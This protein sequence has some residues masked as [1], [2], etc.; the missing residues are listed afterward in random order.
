MILRGFGDDELQD[1][2]WILNVGSRL[3][4]KKMLDDG[5]IGEVLCK[6]YYGELKGLTDLQVLNHR[7]W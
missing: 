4:I 3:D 7:N 5:V 2:Y 1:Q 6:E